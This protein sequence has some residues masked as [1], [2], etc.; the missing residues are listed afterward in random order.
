M[1][2]S[3]ITLTAATASAAAAFF[4][5]SSGHKSPNVWEDWS[6]AEC[7]KEISRLR[8]FEN[9]KYKISNCYFNKFSMQFQATVI[10]DEIGKELPVVVS[11]NSD[12]NY[13]FKK[14]IVIVMGGPGTI[15]SERKSHPVELE[16]AKRCR[17]VI[18]TPVYYGSF[19]R[20]GFPA[21]S[22][23]IAESEVARTISYLQGKNLGVHLIAYSLGGHIVS[24]EDVP[25]PEGWHLLLSPMLRSPQELKNYFSS[26]IFSGNTYAKRVIKVNG[27]PLV[28]E[29]KLIDFQSSYFS[30][31]FSEQN[32]NFIDR[33][34]FKK[35]IHERAHMLAVIAEDEE[36]AGGLEFRKDLE[37]NG[38]LV[39]TVKGKHEPE[40]H[41]EETQR[42][43]SIRSFGEKICP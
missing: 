26:Y 6:S 36:R 42:I 39:S 37:A 18:F 12:D 28:K 8:H 30:N 33:W 19:E 41:D 31:E 7:Q 1:K 27:R 32:S 2:N 40:N 34:A 15:I 3:M 29:V 5:A 11:W 22:S 4:F 13:H 38:F 23:R 10:F 17:A 24:S 20:S 43:S 35:N 14:A 9:S 21:S 25:I 16:V